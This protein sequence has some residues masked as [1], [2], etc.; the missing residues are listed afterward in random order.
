MR[1]QFFDLV[2]LMGCPNLAVSAPHLKLAVGGAT[3]VVL[4]FRRRVVVNCR[5][6]KRFACWFGISNST[7]ICIMPLVMTTEAFYFQILFLA[8]SFLLMTT[9]KDKDLSEETCFRCHHKGHYANKC[10]VA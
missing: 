5:N 6:W 3:L 2:A 4:V 8:E 9:G 10:T 7:F 1:A